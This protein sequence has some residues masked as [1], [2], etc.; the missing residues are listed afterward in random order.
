MNLRDRVQQL[1]NSKNQ[2]RL[3]IFAALSLLYQC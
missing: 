2:I 3:L 1:L